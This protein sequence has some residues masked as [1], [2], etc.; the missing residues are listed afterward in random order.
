MNETALREF[1]ERM[2]HDYE[3]AK[4]D[5]KKVAN[6]ISFEPELSAGFKAWFFKELGRINEWEND[7]RG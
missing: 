4:D 7:L 2:L 1:A 6:T 3:K 5:V